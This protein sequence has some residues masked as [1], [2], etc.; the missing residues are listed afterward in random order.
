MKNQRWVKK[1]RFYPKKSLRE[2]SSIRPGDKILIE[3]QPDRLI[4]RKIYSIKKLLEMAVITEGLAG[5]IETKIEK[6]LEKKREI[7]K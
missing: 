6:E 7:N 3:T 2:Y 5:K 1:V 4:I